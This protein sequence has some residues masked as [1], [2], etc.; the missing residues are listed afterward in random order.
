MQS[1][2]ISRPY[3][4]LRVVLHWV[5][6]AIILWA[7]FSGFL[8]VERPPGD[9]VRRQIDLFN[10]QLTALFIPLFLCR[11]MLYLRSRPW[12]GWSIQPVRIKLAVAGHAM[13][14]ACTALVLG[15]GYL[16]MPDGWRLLGLLPMPQPV[17]DPQQLA[18]IGMLHHIFTA[19]LAML[20]GGHLLAVLS[21]H[22]AGN[23]VLG[24]MRLS[25]A[26]RQ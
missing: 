11:A 7:S 12:R 1:D 19:G 15:T 6:A 24:R 2:R 25:R 14:Y 16:M 18:A 4:L 8:A 20:V 22:R 9:G 26:A 3:P 21:H 10:P 23:P 5:S 13:L 17:R